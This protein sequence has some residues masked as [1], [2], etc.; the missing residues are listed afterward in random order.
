MKIFFL[1]MTYGGNS[2]TFSRERQLLIPNQENLSINCCTE[3]LTQIRF[4]I[5]WVWY[6]H[7]CVPFVEIRRNPLSICLFIAIPHFWSSL[8]EWLNEFG[9][10]VRYLST[11]DI[12]FGLTSKDSLLIFRFNQAWKQSRE[13]INWCSFLKNSPETFWSEIHCGAF[14]WLVRFLKKPESV[15]N[16]PS[17]FWGSV[18]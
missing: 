8:T 6:R 12:A 17:I 15:P 3:L 4:F 1:C 2:S 16:C 5:K 18:L 7:L 11:F 13:G 10:D 9:F 14:F